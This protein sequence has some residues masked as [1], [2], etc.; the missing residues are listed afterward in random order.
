MISLLGLIGLI[1]IVAAF[2]PETIQT[3]KQG[4]VKIPYPFLSLY[5]I[6]SALLTYYA[7]TRNDPVFMILNGLLVLES[8]INLYYKAWPRHR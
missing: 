7:F 8:A 5:F 1:C 4:K 3:I 6:G 2:I